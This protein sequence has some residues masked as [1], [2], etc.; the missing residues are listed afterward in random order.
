VWVAGVLA[1]LLGPV[2]LLYAAPLGA[3]VTAALQVTIGSLMTLLSLLKPAGEAAEGGA[4][5]VFAAYWWAFLLPHGL[6]VVWAVLAADAKNLRLR[7][8]AAAVLPQAIH[9]L[10]PTAVLGALWTSAPAVLG[11]LLLVYL[12]DVSEWLKA[13][14]P[15]GW[16]IYVAVFVVSAGIGFLPTYGQSF[17]GGWTF[18]FA[19]G[20]P[21][22]M[23]GFVGGSVIGFL[24]SRSVAKH[25]VQDVLEKNP[26]AKAVRDALIGQ[27][28][29]KTLG[30]VTLIRVPPNSPFALTNLVLTSSGVGLLPY[31][32]GTAIGMAPRTGIAVYIAAHFGEPGKSIG[33]L[34][35]NQP[36]WTVALGI[37]AAALVLGVIGAIANKAL[38]EVTEKKK[39][40]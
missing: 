40:G 16:L 10:G 36:W 1:L 35:K 38:A 37:A 30:I 29:W 21:G 39:A 15:W 32:I 18:G 24:I 4:L 25:K 27:G 22:A 19:L 7:G 26:K 28:F 9:D 6:G 11:T 17:L 3:V 2:G 14:G 5:S 13:A 8:P 12:G 20:F 33:D 34:L 23:L 31:V